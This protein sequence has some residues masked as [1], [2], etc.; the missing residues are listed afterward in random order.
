MATQNPQ[1]TFRIPQEVYDRL[2]RHWR[3]QTT[4]P[5]LSDLARELLLIGLDTVSPKPDD[6]AGTDAR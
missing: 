5:H 4:Y 2:Y 1:I 3:F 6:A